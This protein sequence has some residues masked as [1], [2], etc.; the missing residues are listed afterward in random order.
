[1]SIQN[2]KRREGKG[3]QAG[4]LSECQEGALTSQQ[5]CF[6]KTAVPR[7]YRDDCPVVAVVGRSLPGALQQFRSKVNRAGVFKALKLRAR[8]PSTAARRRFK[9][10]ESIDRAQRAR[11][12]IARKRRVK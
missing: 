1:M 2:Q 3:S 10:K 9:R 6:V 11:R 7:K 12:K 5:E 4:H 8:Y